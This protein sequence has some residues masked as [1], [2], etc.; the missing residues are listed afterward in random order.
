MP[1]ATVS[2]DG[3]V[4]IPPGGCAYTPDNSGRKYPPYLVFYLAPSP[5]FQQQFISIAEA[6]GATQY[7][8]LPNQT[9]WLSPTGVAYDVRTNDDALAT[10]YQYTY[11]A[12]ADLRGVALTSGADIFVSH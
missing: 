12:I 9:T 8:N 11:Q 2:A 5:D 7:M 1:D 6:A 3:G 4:P 10:D